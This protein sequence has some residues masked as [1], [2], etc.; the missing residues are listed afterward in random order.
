MDS[1]TQDVLWKRKVQQIYEVNLSSRVWS[2]FGLVALEL[3]AEETAVGCCGYN[4][5]CV[6]SVLQLTD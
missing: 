5:L 4:W 3:C 6:I 1:I 2:D